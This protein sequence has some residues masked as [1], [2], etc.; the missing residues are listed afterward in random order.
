MMLHHFPHEAEGELARR[1]AAL[2]Q[3]S[4]LAEVARRIGLGAHLRL[5]DSERAS[6][7]GAK[8]TILADAC[9]AVIGAIYVDGGLSAA[10]TFVERLWSPMLEIASRPPQD[11]K[12]AL[13]EWA[14][15]RGLPV[16]AYREVGR[17]GP[18]HQPRFLIEVT[19]VGRQSERGAGGSK[20]EAEREAARIILARLQSES[21]E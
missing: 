21:R 2:V 4:V 6:G 20:R 13:Q 18:A 9:E 3:A 17:E 14:Q 19:V 11:P 16:P 1:H 12:T 7:G 5:G 8:A 10:A 15:A